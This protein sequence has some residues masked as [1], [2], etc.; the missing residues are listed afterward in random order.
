MKRILVGLD[1]S[2]RAPFVL[3]TATDLARQM[4]A[5][6]F[7]LRT[8]GLPAEIDQEFLVHSPESL[9]EMM[10][11]KG[12][13]ELALLAKDT[14]EELID[15]LEVHVGSPW[16]SICREAKARNCDLVVVGSHG[17]N[18]VDRLLG[19]T[20]SKVVNHCERTVLVVREPHAKS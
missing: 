6:L 17:Y 5:K 11:N 1:G 8:V 18:T 13:T 16:D 19:T 3:K 10:T 15:G 9:S 4:G 14:P 7:L 20:A 2:S 12:R